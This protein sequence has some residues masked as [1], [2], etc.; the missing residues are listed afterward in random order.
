M[1][2]PLDQRAFPKRIRKRTDAPF[3]HSIESNVLGYCSVNAI[4]VLRWSYQ[5]CLLGRTVVPTV[6][7]WSWFTGTRQQVE[8]RLALPVI[9]SGSTLEISAGYGIATLRVINPTGCFPDN[10]WRITVSPR[11]GNVVPMHRGY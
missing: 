9:V 2:T 5:A 10:P 4:V 6:L 11:I 1:I 3:R 7:S 8:E